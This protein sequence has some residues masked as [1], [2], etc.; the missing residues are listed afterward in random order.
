MLGMSLNIVAIR[1]SSTLS[2]PRMSPSCGVGILRQQS[3]FGPSQTAFHIFA[4][5]SAGVHLE[6]FLRRYCI[7]RNGFVRSSLTRDVNPALGLK[8]RLRTQGRKLVKRTECSKR[9]G[10][11]G[12][13]VPEDSHSTEWRGRVLAEARLIVQIEVSHL[14]VLWFH[15]STLHSAR[16][17]LRYLG[18]TR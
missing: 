7:W 1:P 10:I 4:C 18:G 16:G 11:Q 2:T 6:S 5:N 3:N 12:V 14:N 9:P 13:G 17:G 8:R 15:I